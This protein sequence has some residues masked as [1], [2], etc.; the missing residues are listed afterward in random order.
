[1]KPIVIDT[2][3]WHY[4]LVSNMSAD[5]PAQDICGYSKQVLLALLMLFV[6]MVFAYLLLFIVA[7]FIA[8]V[9]ATVVHWITSGNFVFTGG[10]GLLAVCLLTVIGVPTA[11]FILVKNRMDC[12]R[13]DPN[14][15]PGFVMSAWQSFRGRYCV[16]VQ[17]NDGD[18]D[19][20][21]N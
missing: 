13:Y 4:R 7:D 19:G 9:T 15:K 3:S 16:P 11:L 14:Y 12:Q 10:I 20:S 17:Y 21:A 5:A 18:G 1:M 8:A 2:K 6:C